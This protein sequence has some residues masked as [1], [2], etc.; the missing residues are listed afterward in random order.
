MFQIVTQRCKNPENSRQQ[1]ILT[2]SIQ[3]NENWIFSGPFNFRKFW[4]VL[5]EKV[6][7]SKITDVDE[8]KTC[9][10]DEWAQFDQSIVDAAISQ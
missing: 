9:L 2:P 3:D 5:Q 7:H 10:M 4:S 8:L 6:Y 1:R